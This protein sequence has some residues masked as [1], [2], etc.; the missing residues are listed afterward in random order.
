MTDL[1]I[2]YGCIQKTFQEWEEWLNSDNVI[3][4]K[5]SDEKFKSIRLSLELALEQSKLI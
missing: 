2:R 3:E 4:T 1:H 5:R